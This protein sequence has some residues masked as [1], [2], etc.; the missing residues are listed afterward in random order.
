MKVVIRVELIAEW[1]ES[2]TTEVCEFNRPASQVGPETIGLSLEDG[3]QLLQAVQ[4]QVVAAQAWEVGELHTVCPA[5]RGSQRVKDYRVRRIDTVFGTVRFRSPRIVSCDCE[6]PY[7]LS[8]EFCPLMPIIPERSTPELQRLQAT[9]AGQTTYRRA[10]AILSMFLPR[11]S[12]FN[13]ATIRNRTLR[14]G[15]RLDAA[16][17]RP[18]CDRIDEKAELAVA[19]DGGFVR[20]TRAKQ[21]T[22]NFEVMTGRVAQANSKPYVF[23]WVGSEVP[24]PST[25]LTELLG[26]SAT[27]STP[28]IAVI[29]DGG[30]SVQNLHRSVPCDA[31][32]IL[33]WFHISMRIHYV[34]QIVGGLVAK[35]EAELA[36]K[37]QLAQLIENLRW[38][39]WH[40]HSERAE[41]KMR[42]SLLLCRVVVPET[43]EFKEKLDHLDYRLCELLA[44]VN[45]NEASL[46]NYRERYHARK[47]ISTALAESAVNQVIKA[48]MGKSQQMRWSPQGA[49]LLA[50]VRCAVLNGNLLA[51]LSDWA[52]KRAD[53]FIQPSLE[54]MMLM[55]I[56]EQWSASR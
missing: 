43:T 17:Q 54:A 41:A 44:Y 48:R 32:P 38:H 13:H 28:T 55:R 23:A 9:L 3:K 19:I 10:A 14:A 12:N 56:F 49:H 31:T 4:Q 29:T 11:S 18:G 34:E 27:V 42:Q 36:T 22:H 26:V 1:G 6:P 21:G 7:F 46:I 30:S 39:F 35:S 2:T 16:S 51:R 20:A 24:S 5:C 25:R 50:Q 37:R 40:A 15:R 47:P 45:T 33:D 53:E 52:L 8:I